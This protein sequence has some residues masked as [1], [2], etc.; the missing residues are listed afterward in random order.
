LLRIDHP[1]AK[2]FWKP[3]VIVVLLITPG[4]EPDERWQLSAQGAKPK[5]ESRATPVSSIIAQAGFEVE[6]I[7]SA[8]AQEGSWISMTFDDQGRLIL[9]LDAQGIARLTISGD[10]ENTQYELID[11]TLRHCRGILY[12]HHSLYVSATNSKGFYRLRDTGGDDQFDKVQLIKPLDYRSRFGHGSNQVV[13]GPDQNIYLVNGN[14]ISFPVGTSKDSPYRNPQ[15]DHLLP[16]PHDAGHDNRVGHIIRIDPEGKRWEVIAGG[17]RNQFDMAFNQDG[18]MFTYDADMEWD[19]GLPWYRPTRLNHIVSGGEYGWR[20]NTGKWPDY[21]Q[22][23]LPTTLD[24][25]RGSPTAMEFGY[26]SKF[27]DRYRQA[28]YLADW[29]NGRI[30]LV[31]LKP[32][33][34][35]YA[36]KYELFLEGGPLNVCDMAF[37]PDGALYFITGGRGS[38]SGLY[39]VTYAGKKQQPEPATATQEKNEADASKQRALRHQLE[40]YHVKRDSQAIPLIWQHLNSTDR[41]LRFAARTALENQPL[42][43][44]KNRLF[45]EPDPQRAGTA[46]MALARQGEP[47]DL[48]PVLKSLERL[49]W[50]RFK[51]SQLLGILR[52][53]QLA[54]IRLGKPNPA[55]T[56][57]M[58][59]RFDASYPHDN[60]NINHLLCELLVYLKSP[61][62]VKKTLPLLSSISTREAQIRYVR[63]LTHVQDGWDI[64]S[65]QAVLK[66][67]AKARG[68]RGGKLVTATVKNLQADMLTKLTADDRQQLATEIAALEKEEATTVSTPLP[69]VKQWKMDDLLADLSSDSEPRSFLGGKQA[70]QM[71][72]CLKC[73]RINTAGGQVGPDLT[74]VGKR[75]DRRALLESIL[76]PS[77]I[78]DPKYS[79]TAYLM[80]NGKVIVGRPIGVNKGQITVETNPLTTATAT[81]E[82]AEIEES[83]RGKT[84]PMPSGL[85]DVL[86]R[87]QILDLLAYLQAGGNPRHPLYGKDDAR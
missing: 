53:Y 57:T 14:D 40:T 66:W 71:A 7:R 1:F 28:L 72:S 30:L 82:R 15:N 67:L 16:N 34:S 43:N 81:V 26:R 27:P 2:F 85:V 20:W 61:S 84:S 8:T 41:W 24:L 25:G 80:K 42:A 51:T 35:S 77:K 38:Q 79:H 10:P 48:I 78:I 13:L 65:K 70:L 60:E 5:A 39:R 47:G 17:F 87:Q 3:V 21:F 55:A 19:A 9:G 73:H 74:Q 64:T 6:L 54:F 36:G 59:H 33:G 45:R 50:E 63:T 58:L 32:Q 44:W 56:A 49:P 76:L 62:V 23:S 69:V 12:A 31:D 75:F 4:L 29:Q 52:T 46:L 11:K 22:D 68:F 37:G 86:T 83:Q 18:E